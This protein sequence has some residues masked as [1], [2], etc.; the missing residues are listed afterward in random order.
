MK[1]IFGFNVGCKIYK[2]FPKI[3]ISLND[4]LID[5]LVLDDGHLY[6]KHTVLDR[7]TYLD[8]DIGPNWFI[9]DSLFS[10]KINLYTLDDKDLHGK[11]TLKIQ[12]DDNNYTNGFITKST[13][14]NFSYVFLIPEFILYNNAKKIIKKIESAQKIQIDDVNQKK[15]IRWPVDMTY[16]WCWYG[17]SRV[18]DFPII[19]HDIK[20]KRFNSKVGPDEYISSKELDLNTNM[21]DD[22][23]VNVRKRLLE[24]MIKFYK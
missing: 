21:D 7:K 15:L 2:K 13:Q 14:I 12:N 4:R 1:Y 5:E 18:L 9:E 20:Y 10:K 22:V 3:N 16:S 24:I 23:Y 11:I 17:D 8:T 6:N 19:N